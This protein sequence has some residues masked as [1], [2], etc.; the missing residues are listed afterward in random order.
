MRAVDPKVSVHRLYVDP[1]YNPVKQKKQTFSE[2]KGEAILE[3]VDKLL[4][5]NAIREL[6]FLT[7]LANMVLFPKPNG[8]WRMCTDFTSIIIRSALRIA[9]LGP[10]LIGWLTQVPGTKWWTSWLPSGV[11]PD[12][13]SRGG[14][15]KD[16]V[17]K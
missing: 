17:R 5:A 2:E 6:L 16:R 3:E 1:H 15:G 9:I 8:T 10:T 4:G 7:W 12:L 14:R 11:S 13:H